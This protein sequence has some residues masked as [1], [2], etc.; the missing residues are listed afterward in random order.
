MRVSVPM[1]AVSGSRKIWTLI[2]EQII[3]V[4][5]V[6]NFRKNGL[7]IGLVER[8]SWPALKVTLEEIP[9]VRVTRQQVLLKSAFPLEMALD[10]Q[11]RLNTVFYYTPEGSMPGSTY[12]DSKRYL[13]CAHWLNPDNLDEVVLGVTLEIRQDRPTRKP[14]L[15]AQ[16]LQRVPVYQG[17]IFSEFSAMVRCPAGAVL[18]LGPGPAASKSSLPGG[19]FFTS[20][21][22]DQKRETVYF[23]APRVVRSVMAQG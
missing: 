3:P 4:R 15:T 9:D 1:G 6:K 5:R 17:K 14:T 21:G 10:T 16:G 12:P 19:A 18:V 13:H 11:P 22:Q 20:T 2:N 7:R 8:A 23:L